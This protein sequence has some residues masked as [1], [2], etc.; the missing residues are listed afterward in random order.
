MLREVHLPPRMVARLGMDIIQ[1][2]CWL[3]DKSFVHRDIKPANIM[4]SE[5]RKRFV[6][7]D[8]GIALDLY[9]PSLTRLPIVVGTGPYLSPEQIDVT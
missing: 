3:A 8:P 6:L 2:T 9:G 7:L 4:W 5:D 1:A